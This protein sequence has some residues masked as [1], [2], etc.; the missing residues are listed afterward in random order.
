MKLTAAGLAVPCLEDECSPEL[1]GT[2]FVL[3]AAALDWAGLL[4]LIES[5]KSATTTVT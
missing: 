1:A 4:E 3:F 5:T 2:V